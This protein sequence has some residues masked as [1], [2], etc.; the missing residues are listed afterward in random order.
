[1]MY[2]ERHIVEENVHRFYAIDINRDLFGHWLLVRRWG[3]AGRK[4]GQSL[5]MSF[6]TLSDAVSE[7]STLQKTKLKRGYL[8]GQD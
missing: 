6:E 5:T 2:L 7:Q 4:G 1:M 3:R 8:N